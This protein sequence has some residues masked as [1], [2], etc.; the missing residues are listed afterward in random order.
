MS[1]EKSKISGAKILLFLVISGVIVFAYIWNSYIVDRRADEIIRL[2][3]KIEQLNV[4]KLVL[5]ARYEKLVSV[6]YVVPYAKQKLELTFPK[7][8]PKEIIIES[9]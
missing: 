6:N 2:E 1:K 4:E 7:E 3:R 9:E 8:N 5:E